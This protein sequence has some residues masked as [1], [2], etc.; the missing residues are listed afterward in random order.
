MPYG[1]NAPGGTIGEYT[2]SGTPVNASLI[3]NL[4]GP[5]DIAVLTPEPATW[6]ML[7]IGAVALVAAAVRKRFR[8]ASEGQ[9]TVVGR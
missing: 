4:N 7:V 5:S 6:R 1:G 3:T 2:T 8:H 9:L